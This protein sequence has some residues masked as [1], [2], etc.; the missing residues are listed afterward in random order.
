MGE[1]L[2][3]PISWVIDEVL[4]L[5]VWRYQEEFGYQ[6]R[7]KYYSS[8]PE[9]E[10]QEMADV[11]SS[12]EKTDMPTLYATMGNWEDF[13]ESFSSYVHTV[14]LGKPFFIDIQKNGE[15]V[16]R[17]DHCWNDERCA[18]KRRMLEKVFKFP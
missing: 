9:L 14:V 17:Y 1:Y 18:E 10:G 12:L 6:G 2:F 16:K 15:M 7:V 4:D 3:S 5:F 8:S 11:Y 13:A